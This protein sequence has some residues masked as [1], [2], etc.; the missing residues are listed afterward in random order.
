[1]AL[2]ANTDTYDCLWSQMSI[3][4]QNAAL[5]R[6]LYVL[7]QGNISIPDTDLSRHPAHL[8]NSA[9]KGHQ[10]V[11][12]YCSLRLKDYTKIKTLKFWP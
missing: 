12:N 9:A 7:L 4:W 10:G 11:I 5:A 3:S 8:T 1:M 6:I 2:Q